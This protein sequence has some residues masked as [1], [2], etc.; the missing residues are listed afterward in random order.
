MLKG[1]ALSQQVGIARS[2]FS[3]RLLDLFTEA[4]LDQKSSFLLGAILASDLLA[5]KN[6]QALCV[7]NDMKIVIS[8][9]PILANALKEL[10]KNDSYFTGEIRLLDDKKEQP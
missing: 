9:K 8:G 5:I 3:V 1:A 10:I 2:C 7:T 6:S 4:T